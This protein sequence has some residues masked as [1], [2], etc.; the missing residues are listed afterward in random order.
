LWDIF[1]D[2]PGIVEDIP[3]PERR[4]DTEEKLASLFSLLQVWRWAWEGRNIGAVRQVPTQIWSD[5]VDTPLIGEFLSTNLEFTSLDQA[6]DLLN[7]NAALLYVMQLQ[8]A[9]REGTVEAKSLGEG[10]FDLV[11][12]TSR[13]NGENPLLLPGQAVLLCQ[14][15]IEALR[16]VPFLSGKLLTNDEKRTLVTF[17]PLSAVYWTLMSQP[18]WAESMPAILSK[19]LVFKDADDAFK[20]HKI[21]LP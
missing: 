19:L 5:F 14:P 11:R 20:G 12:R 4:Q 6:V 1:A 8:Q 13:A 16:M 9:L 7:Y 15:A 10:D 18:E 3:I 17:T 2:L 21:F